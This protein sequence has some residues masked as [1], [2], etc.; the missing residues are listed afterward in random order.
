MKLQ[1]GKIHTIDR[2]SVDRVDPCPE[3]MHSQRFMKCHGMRHRSPFTIRRD[4]PH[5]SHSRQGL[6]ER[7]QPRRVNPIIIRDQNTHGAVRK[8]KSCR[9]QLSVSVLSR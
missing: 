3:L 4:H 7:R 2:R 8:K 1:H 9:R 5:F 6:G